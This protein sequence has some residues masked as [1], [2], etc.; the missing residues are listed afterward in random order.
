MWLKQVEELSS[1]QV[2]VYAV[3]GGAGGPSP[4]CRDSGSSSLNSS[5]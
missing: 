5:P 3:G 4:H 2:K 1:S